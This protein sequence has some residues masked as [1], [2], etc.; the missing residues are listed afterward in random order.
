MRNV[1]LRQLLG[2]S[3][4]LCIVA[5]RTAL[6]PAGWHV[7]SPGPLLSNRCDGSAPMGEPTLSN[8]FLYVFL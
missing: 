6:P 8:I 5:C 7:P 3:S 2:I 4:F 1:N